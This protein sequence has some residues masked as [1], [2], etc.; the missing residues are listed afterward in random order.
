M[1]F[2]IELTFHYKI[3]QKKLTFHSLTYSALRKAH[4]PADQTVHHSDSQVYHRYKAATN[5]L[6]SDFVKLPKHPPV[7]SELKMAD[8]LWIREVI[9]DLLVQNVENHVQKV[10]A[11]K[12]QLRNF[13]P[14]NKQLVEKSLRA[15]SSIRGREWRTTWRRRTRWPEPGTSPWTRPERPSRLC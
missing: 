11:D 12:G 8:L 15:V 6:S 13:T 5:F 1:D 4:G 10:P 14:S 3:N 7:I 9:V 2:A